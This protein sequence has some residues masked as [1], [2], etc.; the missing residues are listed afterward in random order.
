MRDELFAIEKIADKDC[1]CTFEQMAGRIPTV[2]LSCE[3]R[4][5][6]NEIG[7]LCRNSLDELN[8]SLQSNILCC[9]HYPTGQLGDIRTLYP[10]DFLGFHGII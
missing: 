9:Q 4:G 1:T 10:L 2:C 8:R 6:L 7:D 3:A 5:M